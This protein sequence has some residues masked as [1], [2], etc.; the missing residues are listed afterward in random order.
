MSS[1]F[2]FESY[3]HRI[4]T[5]TS[6]GAAL[7]IVLCVALCIVLFSGCEKE[8]R[9]TLRIDSIRAVDA[10]AEP[11]DLSI[12]LYDSSDNL[13]SKSF[14]SGELDPEKIGTDWLSLRNTV[15]VRLPKAMISGDRV[16][17]GTIKL[18]PNRFATPADAVFPI[19]INLAEAF[20]S[21]IDMMVVTLTP[22]T[23]AP[24]ELRVE[25]TEA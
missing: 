18:N 2:R 14:D 9:Y 25:F 15:P 8:S 6:P 5:G 22:R 24:F 17:T 11:V 21:E 12:W 7:R 23:D 3:K 19:S 16:L 13:I 10:D 20:E 4:S 1:G